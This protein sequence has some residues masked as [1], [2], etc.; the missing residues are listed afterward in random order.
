[1]RTQ[2]EQDI[3]AAMEALLVDPFP[4]SHCGR[5]IPADLVATFDCSGCPLDVPCVR[6][7]NGFLTAWPGSLPPDDDDDDP[8]PIVP[9]PVVPGV[10][11]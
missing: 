11:A 2:E 7:G 10:A 6:K 3:A 5:T 1:M 4:C 9:Q 8:E